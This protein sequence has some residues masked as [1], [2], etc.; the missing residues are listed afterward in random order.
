MSPSTVNVLPE[1]LFVPIRTCGD[2]FLGIARTSVDPLRT[3]NPPG[4]L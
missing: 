4:E 1:D 2:A 3:T